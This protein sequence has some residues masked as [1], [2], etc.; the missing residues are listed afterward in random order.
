[1][2]NSVRDSGKEAAAERDRSQQ[3][4]NGRYERDGNVLFPGL[5]GKWKR[6]QEKECGQAGS[7]PYQ[8]VPDEAGYKST[9][10][11]AK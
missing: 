1:M 2:H 6:R 3:K 11:E 9:S 7:R 10:S 8:F 5:G 4:Q